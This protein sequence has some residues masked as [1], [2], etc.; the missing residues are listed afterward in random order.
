MASDIRATGKKGMTNEDVLA[1]LQKRFKQGATLETV[2]KKGEAM[3]PCPL[4]AQ[5]FRELG[6]H[7]ENIGKDAKGGVIGP[8]DMNSTNVD[9]LDKWDG[10][11]TQSQETTQMRK[12]NIRT[13]NSKTPPFTES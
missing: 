8:N 4:C 5:I 11:F 12:K 6:I 7:P 13:S 3:A 1:E 10:V 2:N 9:K